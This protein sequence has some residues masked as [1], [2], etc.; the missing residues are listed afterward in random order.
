MKLLFSLLLFFNSV[1]TLSQIKIN[2]IFPAPDKNQSEW[3]EIYNPNETTVSID[4][5][6]VTSRSQNLFIKDTINFEPNSFFILAKDAVGVVPHTNCKLL[7]VPLPTLHND[8]DAITIRT[9]DSSLIDSIYYN[10]S[11]VKKGISIERI[12]WS[13]PGYILSNL[14][15][16]NDTNQQTICNE[17]SKA[18]KDFSL[19]VNVAFNNGTC[20]LSFFNLGRQDIVEINISANLSFFINK[21]Y[22]E[23]EIF[24]SNVSLLKRKDSTRIEIPLRQIFENTNAEFIEKLIFQISYDSSSNK[25]T[26]KIEVPLQIPRPFTSLLIN[27]ILFD[28][29]TGCGEFIELMN[30]SSDTISIVGWKI[31]NSSNKQILFDLSSKI[32]DIPPNGFFVVIWDSVFYNCFEDLKGREFFYYRGSFSLRN[33]GDMILFINHIGLVQDSLFYFPEWHKGKFTNYKQKSLEKMI[34]TEKSYISENWFTS[35]DP[36]GATPGE[37]NSVSFEKEEKISLE[38][39]P[40]PFS[41]NSEK[42]SEAKIKYKL[43]YKQSRINIKIFDLNGIEIYNLANNVVSPSSGEIS[44]NGDTFFGEKATPGGYVIFF[45]AVDIITGKVSTTKKTIAVGW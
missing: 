22:F 37:I 18:I 8:W 31:V 30:T 33:T 10:S 40:N 32:V 16:C 24:N 1:I 3:I 17:N 12:D 34:P 26:R 43:P 15:L 5:L 41:P 7:I 4:G 21:N 29:Y 44:W 28:V 25:K 42:K 38:V 9:R 19:D 6:F 27:E 14:T 13:E 20:L 11:L 23:K 36:R 35:V 39:E 2:E 45:E